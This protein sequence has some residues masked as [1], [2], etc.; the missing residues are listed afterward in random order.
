MK[1]I[2]LF[3]IVLISNLTFSQNDSNS[4]ALDIYNRRFELSKPLVLPD[5]PVFKDLQL[6]TIWECLNTLEIMYNVKEKIDFTDIRNQIFDRLKEMA[7][8]LANEGTYFYLSNGFECYNWT[9][10]KNKNYLETRELYK[11]IGD[12]STSIGFREGIDILNKT[13]KSIQE[14]KKKIKN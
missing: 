8:I 11:C 3:S 14:S 10:E 2:I 7:T 13:T 9:L 5:Y 1:K 6:N 12:C 4:L